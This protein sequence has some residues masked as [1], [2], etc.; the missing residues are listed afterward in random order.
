MEQLN[1]IGTEHYKRFHEK[2]VPWEQVLRIIFTTK[3]KKKGKNI[4]E[5]KNKKFYVLCCKE[6]DNLKVINAK[7]Q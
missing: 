7:K 2:D 3:S 6:G 4:F 5:F 1:I